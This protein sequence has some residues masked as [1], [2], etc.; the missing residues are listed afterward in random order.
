VVRF[1][2]PH[3]EIRTWTWGS[4]RHHVVT[5]QTPPMGHPT[6]SRGKHAIAQTSRGGAGARTPYAFHCRQLPLFIGSKSVHRLTWRAVCIDEACD[7][8]CLDGFR[9][10]GLAAFF[11]SQKKKKKNRG[12]RLS[13]VAEPRP[14]PEAERA[15]I[16]WRMYR[17]QSPVL[18]TKSHR[19]AMIIVRTGT[20]HN[21]QSR[22]HQRAMLRRGAGFLISPMRKSMAMGCAA[23]GL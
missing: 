22:M 11:V 4:R 23:D 2:V 8:S 16:F 10:V 17:V 12:T 7:S 18:K 6:S 14:T 13:V 21:H 19:R 20:S 3:L 15:T 9:Y 5:N 1:S